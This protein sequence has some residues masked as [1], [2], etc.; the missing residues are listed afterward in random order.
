MD[1]F[2]C[3]FGLLVIN[4]AIASGQRGFRSGGGVDVATS[5]GAQTANSLKAADRALDSQK[6]LLQIEDNNQAVSSTGM[7]NSVSSS[8]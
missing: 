6:A 1:K 4:L 2:L 8:S 7:Q 5:Q 3:I